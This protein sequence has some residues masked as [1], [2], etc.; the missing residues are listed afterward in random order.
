[1]LCHTN[2]LGIKILDGNEVVKNFP[3]GKDT[4]KI[5]YDEPT[6]L[7]QE[8]SEE[9]VRLATRHAELKEDIALTKEQLEK[10]DAE[11]KEL[12]SACEYDTVKCEITLENVTIK[13][14]IRENRKWDTEMLQ[15]LLEANGVDR[16]A[17]LPAHI[18]L[19]LS[20]TAADLDALPEDTRTELSAA[21]E[22][23]PSIVIK[24]EIDQ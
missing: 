11:L 2:I 15:Q 24:V 6:P 19:G 5:M 12:L 22:I 16:I 23:K 13:Q 17:D 14:T 1:M 18:K 21:C 4:E 9:L 10:V 20:I 7:V 8:N 3:I